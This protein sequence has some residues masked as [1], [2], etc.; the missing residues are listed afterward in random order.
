MSI[1]ASVCSF[2]WSVTID[3]ACPIVAAI[4]LIRDV[5][6]E[7]GRPINK[8]GLYPSKD[9]AIRRKFAVD[10][11]VFTIDDEDGVVSFKRGIKTPHTSADWLVNVT[12]AVRSAVAFHS[13]TVTISIPELNINSRPLTTISIIPASIASPTFLSAHFTIPDGVPDRWFPH[14][15]GTPMLYNF[16]ITL[17]LSETSSVAFT[18]RSGFRTIQLVQT[19]VTQTD[20]I[21][22]GITPGDQWHFEI[23]GKT[24]YSSG[25]NIIVCHLFPTRLIPGPSVV[26]LGCS[27]STLS[28]P[29]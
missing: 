21:E 5:L 18:T 3:S 26:L 4:S 13:P 27:L 25:T 14:N 20:V 24:F 16:T 10:V 11:G 19:Q 28:M 12:L 17:G 7:L 22:R 9:V 23:N 8:I 1:L 2:R 29:A 15:L 6:P